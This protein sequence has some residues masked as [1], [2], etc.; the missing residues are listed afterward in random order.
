MDDDGG[1]K[2]FGGFK[3][4]GEKQTPD[5]LEYGQP[6]MGKG[7]EQGKDKG[8]DKKGD[9]YSQAS[10]SRIKNS[11]EKYFFGNRADHTGRQEKKHEIVWRK[12]CSD[13]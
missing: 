6:A 2:A 4:Q 12:S 11:P 13:Q 3:G 9:G 10:Q 5:D 1:D 8:G 7:V